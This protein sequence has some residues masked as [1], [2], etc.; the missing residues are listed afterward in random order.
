M[1]STAQQFA[2]RVLFGT[3]LADKLAPPPTSGVFRVRARP[4]SPGRPPELAFGRGAQPKFPPLARLGEPLL[5]GRALH[6]FANHELLALELFALALLRF[7]DDAAFVAETL[8]TMA[9]EQRH[10]RL[11]LGRMEQLG[12]AFGDLAVSSFFWDCLKDVDS[13]AGFHAAMGLTFEQA[14][15]DFAEHYRGAFAAVG[16]AETAAILRTVHA[17]EVVH[18]ARGRAA[19]QRGGELTFDRWASLLVEPITPRRGRGPVFDEAGRLKAGLPPAFIDRVRAA[20]ASRGRP[21][22]VWWWWADAEDSIAGRTDR[23]D[24]LRRDLQSLP[25]LLAS[26]DDVVAMEVPPT[27]AFRRQ[28]ADVGFPTPE[29]RSWGPGDPWR[30]PVGG[31]RPW[32]WSPAVEA[33]LAPMGIEGSPPRR[34]QL[35]DKGWHAELYATVRPALSGPLVEPAAVVAGADAA[36]VAERMRAAGPVVL[37]EPFG[38]AGRGQMRL[39]EPALSDAQ[40]GWIEGRP[41]LRVEPW[42]PR[43][44]DLA[45]LYGMDA[46]GRVRTLGV[47]RFLTDRRGAF[48]GVLPGP[49]T[50]GL[51]PELRRFAAA[52]G[53]SAWISELADSLGDAVAPALAAR[54][55]R[56]VFGVDALVTSDRRLHPLVELNPRHTLGHVGLALSRRVA[57]G[58]VALWAPL[59]VRKLGD[60]PGWLAR[61]RERLPLALRRGQVLRGVVP[62]N[63][64]AHA[65]AVL[66]VLLVG[67]DEAAV[68]EALGAAA[69]PFAAALAAGR[70]I[71]RP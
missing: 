68:L 69:A 43:A 15:L 53:Q 46:G 42:L 10:L 36:A 48:L 5:A 63:D 4:E 23:L 49:W 34:A 26:C 56:G 39:L 22:T 45:F 13:V 44:V 21:P 37:K 8:R 3:S 16:D 11:Y 35:Y 70:D 18:V 62:T 66:G 6:S 9:D 54:G 40:R 30:G 50:R 1:T 38:T 65:E 17:D 27:S 7:G 19:L 58:R 31:T 41:R 60:L 47:Q 28:L 24:G 71:D 12:V 2:E 64:P 67:P 51:A 52:D 61:A 14:N 32:G 33:A 55:H 20:G 29:V 25:L 57:A 59:P